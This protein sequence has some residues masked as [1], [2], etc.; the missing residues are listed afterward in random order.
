M[1]HIS[2]TVAAE[3]ALSYLE[4]EA[5][6]CWQAA[7][8]SAFG[9]AGYSLNVQTAP[10]SPENTFWSA[11]DFSPSQIGSLKLGLDRTTAV[12]LGHVLLSAKGRAS[13][14]DHHALHATTHLM[15]QFAALLARSLAARLNTALTAEDCTPASEAPDWPHGFTV[16]FGR[17]PNG[18][19][20]LRVHPSP[21]L[22]SALAGASPAADSGS[23]IAGSRGT[24]RN[25]DLLL[26]LEMPVSVSFGSTCLALKDVAKLT[27]GSVVELNRALSE[28]VDIIVNNCAIARG[29]VVVVDGSFAVR[30]NQV[31]SKQDRLRSLS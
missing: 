19:H 4:K 31:M 14:H 21:A 26:D 24:P 9:S 3:D 5:D 13:E 28:P 17:T 1:L 11:C 15:G 8:E 12:A 7:L 6:A 22:L 29:E 25:L 16:P 18:D 30:I 27:T 20:L 23:A 2:T 10:V